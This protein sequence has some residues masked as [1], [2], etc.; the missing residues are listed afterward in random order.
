MGPPPSDPADLAAWLGGHWT[1]QRT[2]NG[3]TPSPAPGGHFTGDVQFTVAADGVITWDERGQLT[4][5]AYTGPAWRTLTIH[6]ASG[7][8]EV[9]FDDGRPFH[10]LDLRT[11]TWTAEHLCGADVYRGRF[12][13]H[14]GETGAGPDRFT[15]TW[16][17]TGPG[18][19]DTIVS[20]YRRDRLQ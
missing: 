15:V 8:W 20:D 5:G 12:A 17:V 13:T 11:G 6:P 4:L 10:D 7:R 18:R 14:P 16:H 3:D 9:R 19:D 2:I 1:V